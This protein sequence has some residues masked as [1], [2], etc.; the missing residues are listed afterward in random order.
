[1]GGEYFECNILHIEYNKE[2]LAL[3]RKN[4]IILA[5]SLKFIKVNRKIYKKYT[6]HIHIY[7]Q[8]LLKIKS[9]CDILYIAYIS[10]FYVSLSQGR[11]L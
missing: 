5:K 4:K 8:I 2:A 10:I 7:S 9:V 6:I 1:M 3:S 11:E